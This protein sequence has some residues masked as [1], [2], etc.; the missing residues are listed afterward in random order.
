LNLH[1]GSTG[2]LVRSVPLFV[3]TL[4]SKVVSQHSYDSVA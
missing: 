4:Q 1:P 3:M 2:G